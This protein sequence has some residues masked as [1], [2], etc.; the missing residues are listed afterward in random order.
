[1]RTSTLRTGTWKCCAGVPSFVS[2]PPSYPSTLLCFVGCSPRPT[3]PLQSRPMGVPVFGHQ[4]W[5]RISPHS[6]RRYISR[7]PLFHQHGTRSSTDHLTI[8]RFPERNR[9][10]DF[11]TF[12]SLLRITAKYEMPTIQSQLLEVVRSAYPQNFEGLTPSKPLGEGVFSGPTP[13]PNEVLNL[14]IHQELTSALSM[15]YYMAARRGLDSLMD[16]LLSRNATLSPEV[17]QS[18]IRG[19]M[20]LREVELN[21]TRSLIFGPK[22]SRPCSS[23]NCPSLAPTG[24]TALATYRKVFNHIVGSSRLG[25]KVL[26]IPEFYEDRGRDLR[27]VG[28]AICR[29]CVERWEHGHAVLR[30]KVWAMFPD[31]FGL[32]D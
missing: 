28:P 32:K 27:C 2:T 22:G 30:K 21:E 23:S 3:W 29:S 24:P 4:T 6:S 16:R 26:Q 31:V 17:L 5:P 15:A 18:A 10:P 9:V 25:T 12:S 13:H 19:L 8:Y 20:A 14:F 7:G 1:M 11:A